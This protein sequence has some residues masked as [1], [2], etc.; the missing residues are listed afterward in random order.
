MLAC[1]VTC[2]TVDCNTTLEI[3]YGKFIRLDV[4]RYGII[5]RAR[6]NSFLSPAFDG[7]D[8]GMALFQVLKPVLT[9][10]RHDYQ[11]AILT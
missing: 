5:L 3:L 9:D 1:P 8:L 2:I 10:S 11:L 6:V 7:F 4:K